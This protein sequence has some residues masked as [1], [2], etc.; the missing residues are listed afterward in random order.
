MAPR[1]ELH[2][3]LKDILGSNNVY[4]QQPT[5]TNMHYPA[6]VYTR[7]RTDAQYAD[8]LAYLSYRRYTV[9]VIDLDPDSEIPDAIMKLP[10]CSHSRSFV[11]NNLNHFVLD[12]YF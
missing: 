11:A 7:D 4:F 8:D 9:T 12:L 10:L 6:I 2:Q 3:M 1:L 5:N